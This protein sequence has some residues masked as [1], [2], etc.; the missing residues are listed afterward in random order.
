MAKNTSA[1]VLIVALR[2]YSYNEN[3]VF[4]HEVTYK[5]PKADRL[6]MLRTVQK[7]LEPV[8]LIYPD[9]ENITID[10]FARVARSQALYAGEDAFKLN[11]RFGW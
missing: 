2:L 5:A 11:I 4:P 6:N 3:K 8:F 10:F 7:D 1:Q 9:E